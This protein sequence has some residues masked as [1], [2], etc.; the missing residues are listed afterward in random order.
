MKSFYMNLDTAGKLNNNSS[1]LSNP[2]ITVVRWDWG[3]RVRITLSYR[4]KIAF[5]PLS[6]QQFQNLPQ[7][8][9][10]GQPLG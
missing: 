10:H 3:N 5:S 6:A 4:K 2:T 1:R 9:D 7:N 8:D